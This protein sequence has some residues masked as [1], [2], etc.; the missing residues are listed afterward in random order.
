MS[1]EIAGKVFSTREDLGLSP[2]SDEER[3]QALRML[4]E[5]KAQR[6]AIPAEERTMAS[7]KFYDDAAGTEFEG[8]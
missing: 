8:Q 2:L 4:A 6:D 3:E 1:K 7:P 5:A